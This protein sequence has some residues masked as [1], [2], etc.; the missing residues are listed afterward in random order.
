MGTHFWGFEKEGVLPDIVT[1]GKPMGNGYPIAAV[2]TTREI[3]DAYKKKYTYFNTYAGNAVACQ[4]ASAVLEVIEEEKLQENALEVGQFLKNELEKLIPEFDCVGAVYGHAMYLGVDIVS[5]K[6]TRKPDSNK[7]LLICEAMK[8]K[9]III[10]PTGDY[11]NILKIKPP[12]CFTE[13]DARFLIKVI[14]EILSI[15]EG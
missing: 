9:G 15:L 1:L 3:A 12:L 11:Y 6:K 8:K 10:Y 2:I 7:A 13:N 5:D 4:V 14:K